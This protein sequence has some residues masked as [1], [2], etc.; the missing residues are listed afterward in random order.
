MPS[1]RS[2]ALLLTLLCTA[3]TGCGF[4]SGFIRGASSSQ[5]IK[6]DSRT[7]R[8]SYARSVS[9]D[10]SAGWLFCLI[11]IK[12]VPLYKTAMERLH[13]AARLRA[14][15]ALMNLREDRDRLTYL[16]FWCSSTLT[17]SADVMRVSSSSS[18][19]KRLAAKTRKGAPVDAVLSAGGNSEAVLAAGRAPT[20][21]AASIPSTELRKC[22]GGNS[23]ACRVVA[24]AVV[25]GQ[26]DRKAV[27]TALEG[28][29]AR[30]VPIACA[31]AR[32]LK[33]ESPPQR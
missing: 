31:T 13:A 21:R 33:V 29:C 4:S 24:K 15:E 6:Y 8:V 18:H 17:I 20:P 16:G 22:A 32:A 26:L 1:L 10:A 23:E 28:A 14:D 9:G 30:R 27:V 19:G 2:I 11:P 25:A 5:V 12:S 7:T 3:S